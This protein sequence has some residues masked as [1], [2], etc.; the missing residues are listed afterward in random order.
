MSAHSLSEARALRDTVSQRPAGEIASLYAALERSQAVAEFSLDGSVLRANENFLSLFGYREDELLGQHHRVLCDERTGASPD[1][2]AFWARLRSGEFVSGQFSRRHRDGHGVHIQASYNAV[3]DDAGRPVAVVKFAFDVSEVRRRAFEADSRIA[4]ID[5]TQAVI[6]FG[7][8]GTILAANDNYLAALGYARDEVLGQHHRMLCDEAQAAGAD[9]RFFWEDLRAGRH[10]TGEF[11]RRRKD[12]AT[13]WLLAAY[14][15]V[16]DI[17]GHASKV[18]KYAIDVSEAKR[19]AVAATGFN[20]ALKAS[21]GVIEF[22]LEGRVLAANA[23]MQKALGYSEAEL[24]GQSHTMLCTP[25][26]A[27]STDYAAFWQ[28]LRE[29]RAQAGEFMRLGRN[30]QPV[31]LQAQYTPVAGADGRPATVVKFARE[32]TA[33]KLKSLEDDGKVAAINRSQGVIEFDLS[34]QVLWANENFLVLTGY[35]LEEIRGQHHRLFVDRDEA[36]G[37]GYRAF[38]KKLGSGSFDTGEYLRF[39][40]NGRRVWIQA[41]YNPILDLEGH[42]VKVV[43][44]CIDVTAAKLAA[45]ENEARMA[46]LSA[47]SCMAELAPDG[48][49][50]S[51]NEPFARALGR[52][53]AELI[54]RPQSEALFEADARGGEHARHWQAFRDGQAVNGELRCRAGGEREVWLAASMTPVMGLDGHLAKVLLIARDVTEDKRSRLDV[55]AKLSAID[56]SQAVI[57]FDLAGRVLDANANFLRLTGYHLDDVKGRHHRLF[58]DPA[59]AASPEYQSFWERLARGEV[60]Q[61]EYKRVGRDGR[62]VWIQATYNP[63]FDPSG[64]PVKVVKFASD[65]TEAKLRAAEFAAKVNAIDLSQAVVEFDLDGRVLSANRNFLAAMGYTL[66]EVQGQHHSLF[67][68]AEYQQSAEYRDFWLRLNE[69]QFIGGRF[70]R[71]GKFGRDVWIQASYNPILD[72][73]G[74]VAKVVKV[75][76]DVTAEVRLENTIASKSREMTGRIEELARSIGEIAAGTGSASA[77]ADDAAAAA[78]A[79]HDAVQKSIAAI[80]TIQ[81]GSV[82]MSEIVRAIGEIASQTNLLAFNAAIEAARAGA[83]GIGFS[84]VAGEVRK[85]AERSSEAAREITRL[86]DESGLHVDNG[87]T[88]S[89]NA[90]RGFEGVMSKVEQ[91]GRNVAG[92]AQAAERQRQMAESV[93]AL[94]LQLKQAVGQ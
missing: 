28:A 69:G 36:G 89:R 77:L 30:A 23:V 41:S 65:V 50:L 47:S 68:S 1:Y 39:G 61:G 18:V 90:A 79:G 31:W 27:R 92:I 46:A 71:V 53:R 74:H 15:P 88:V 78:R 20:E 80:D 48:T 59:Q 4:A 84:V 7:L 42:P 29:G 45:A 44:Y 33:A 93:S 94:I 51:V 67:C 8:D 91:T 9:Y 75:A 54:G 13:V 43:K 72:L 55:T 81:A 63:V 3:L 35:T 82:K 32:I 2:E 49:F 12:G 85:L 70:H 21:Q 64:Q 16:L 24:V 19:R 38:W 14:M 66:R 10:R 73:N 6:E 56:R 22:D 57:E 37:A 86:I 5:R 58:V 87:A 11:A 34:G 25:E 17:D 83:H 52:T 26:Y 62:E 76:Q 40:K 60:E